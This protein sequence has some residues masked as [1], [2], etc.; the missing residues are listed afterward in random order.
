MGTKQMT[1]TELNIAVAY[2]LGYTKDD[3]GGTTIQRAIAVAY[4]Y[5]KSGILVELTESAA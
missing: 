3:F 4:C 5:E 2:A 1:G